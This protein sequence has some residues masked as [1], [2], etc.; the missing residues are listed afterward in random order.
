[1]ASKPKAMPSSGLRKETKLTNDGNP[2]PRAVPSLRVL[3]SSGGGFRSSQPPSA[4][5]P[6]GTSDRIVAQALAGER[7]VHRHQP[8]S[9]EGAWDQLLDVRIAAT[10]RV[11]PS[12]A[13]AHPVGRQ[14]SA[15]A[16][17]PRSS[18]SVSIADKG[19]LVESTRRG[20]GPDA[21]RRSHSLPV[22]P[23][24]KVSPSFRLKTEAWALERRSLPQECFAGDGESGGE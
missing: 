16:Q 20:H 6:R 10:N 24:A 3:P 7:Q 22:E 17:Y 9:G 8:V 18:S 4:S 5:D 15:T 19:P 12:A 21:A 11:G 1:M 13:T 2:R 23:R 14:P